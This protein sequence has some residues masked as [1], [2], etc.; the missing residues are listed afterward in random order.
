MNASSVMRLH[1]SL[2]I[3]P[4]TLKNEIYKQSVFFWVATR[5]VRPKARRF[6]GTCHLHLQFFLPPILSSIP[7]SSSLK[8]KLIRSFETLDFFE[9]QGDTNQ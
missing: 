8:M 1:C 4:N 9:L 3:D 5:V 7:Y 2:L 6:E